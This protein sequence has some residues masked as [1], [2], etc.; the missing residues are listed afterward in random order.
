MVVLVKR[1]DM[2]GTERGRWKDIPVCDERHAVF[3]GTRRDLVFTAAAKKVVLALVD[4]WSDVFLFIADG[5][6]FHDLVGGV[7]C[8]T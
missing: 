8:E 5:H 6:P 7:I 2:G 3:P 4:G 1:F